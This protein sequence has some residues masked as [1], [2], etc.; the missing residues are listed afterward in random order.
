M[1]T[2]PGRPPRGY[3]PCLLHSGSCTTSL[4]AYCLSLVSADRPHRQAPALGVYCLSA[5]RRCI[6]LVARGVPASGRAAGCPA[7]FPACCLLPCL[8]PCFASGVGCSGCVFI[9]FWRP[10]PCLGAVS[11]WLP[12]LGFQFRFWRLCVRVPVCCLL[13]LPCL[14]PAGLF[15]PLLCCPC[16]CCTWAPSCLLAF[17]ALMLSLAPPV[18]RAGCAFLSSAPACLVCLQ[19]HDL[20]PPTLP[21]SHTCKKT[22]QKTP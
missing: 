7:A 14:L 22:W 21:C 19:K 16:A 13:F 12:A 20:P 6:F 3:L 17:L 9:A 11:S 1:I 8:L 15:L 2:A 5:I 18:T 10:R 4:F